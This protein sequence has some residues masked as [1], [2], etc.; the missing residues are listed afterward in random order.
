[1]ASALVLELMDLDHSPVPGKR[2]RNTSKPVT[3]SG[4]EVHVGD[5]VLVY[6]NVESKD[7]GYWMYKE[8]VSVDRKNCKVFYGDGDGDFAKAED[9]YYI[10]EFEKEM[11]ESHR[12]DGSLI[13]LHDIVGDSSNWCMG[14]KPGGYHLDSPAEPGDD[15]EYVA[16]GVK[17]GPRKSVPLI[18]QT[19]RKRTA[20]ANLTIRQR[21]S[22][23]PQKSVPLNRAPRKTIRVHDKS[24]RPQKSVPL[25]N[26]AARKRTAVAMNRTIDTSDGKRQQR[27]IGPQKSVPLNRAPRKT[28]RVHEGK[29][30]ESRQP[31]EQDY[32]QSDESGGV[33][34]S[35][36]RIN[37]QTTVMLKQSN[38]IK[39]LEE[40]VTELK[41]ALSKKE[42]E[43]CNLHRVVASLYQDAARLHQDA[44]RFH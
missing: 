28:I 29:N 33:A 2:P 1:M 11:W 42:T 19:V 14:Y 32:Q 22:I 37:Y 30:S 9:T 10:N 12:L 43:C 21:R 25:I 16:P 27:S 15:D 23:G 20:V 41:D 36:E 38:K 18:D 6:A 34:S 4:H 24:I 40:Q 44:G 13:K 3:W 39:S 17:T 5:K 8:V 7:G 26:Q 31:A 35:E